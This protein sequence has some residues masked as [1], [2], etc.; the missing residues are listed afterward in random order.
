M[1]GGTLFFIGLAAFFFFV[2]GRRKAHNELNSPQSQRLYQQRSPALIALIL[3]HVGTAALGCPASAA[4]DIG[5]FVSGHGF[6]RA[7]EA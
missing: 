7:V 2:Y 1:F 5:R 6:S 3:T 4:R